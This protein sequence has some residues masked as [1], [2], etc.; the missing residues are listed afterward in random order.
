MS[1]DGANQL[2]MMVS[3]HDLRLKAFK[4]A[5]SEIKGLIER[6]AIKFDNYEVRAQEREEKARNYMEARVERE[7]GILEDRIDEK[8][9]RL[10]A[11]VMALIGTVL[12]SIIVLFINHKL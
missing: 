7:I 3:E 6:L 8:I 4:E 5:F 12:A 9:N 10:Q 1:T 11:W 2:A